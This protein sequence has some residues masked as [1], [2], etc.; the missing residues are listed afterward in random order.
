MTRWQ[1][2]WFW[3]PA[4]ICCLP[5]GG[6]LRFVSV[7]FDLRMSIVLV[8]AVPSWT[9]RHRPLDRYPRAGAVSVDCGNND[10]SPQ[11][12]RFSPPVL[13]TWTTD[14]EVV[15]FQPAPGQNGPA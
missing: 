1:L 3:P 8:P 11:S 2:K 7:S 15:Q 10:G 5:E 4:D 12:N 14:V 9:A 6:H 13:A